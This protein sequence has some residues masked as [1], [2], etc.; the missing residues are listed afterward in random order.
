MAFVTAWNSY[1]IKMAACPNANDYTNVLRSPE[2]ASGT[3]ARA[4][5]RREP[6][7]IDLEA[8][9]VGDPESLKPAEATPARRRK[10]LAPLD[11][12]TGR[13]GL[14]L[15]DPIKRAPPVYADDPNRRGR[16]RHLRALEHSRW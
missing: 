6:P 11:R 16:A 7:T 3:T 1:S 14:G 9:V 8:T 5:A 13:L 4:L 12:M 15:R 2:A 10:H